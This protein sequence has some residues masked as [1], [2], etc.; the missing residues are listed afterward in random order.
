MRELLLAALRV[1]VFV[2]QDEVATCFFGPLHC[3]PKSARMSKV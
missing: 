1:E 3:D 2:A